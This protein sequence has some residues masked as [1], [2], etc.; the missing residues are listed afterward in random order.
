MFFIDFQLDFVKKR[1]NSDFILLSFLPC[2]R[3]KK[4]IK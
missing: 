1:K 4:N 3:N 2:N